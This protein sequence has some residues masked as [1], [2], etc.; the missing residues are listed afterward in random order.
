MEAARA[1]KATGGTVFHARRVGLKE[2]ET[3]F[4]VTIQP[5][6]EVVMILA[7][8]SYK[9]EIMQS[10]TA[11]SG[12]QTEAKTVVFSLPVNDVIGLADTSSMEQLNPDEP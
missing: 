2:A 6:K 12:L 10:I 3:F 5:E 8:R 7:K 1:A 9:Q 11:K 4:G